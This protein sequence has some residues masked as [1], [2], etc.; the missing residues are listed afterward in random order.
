MNQKK[1]NIKVRVALFENGMRQ[2]ELAEMID[3]SESTMS[4]I[5]RG[6]LSESVQGELVKAINGD[7]EAPANAKKMLQ[8]EMRRK[9]PTMICKPQ[10][11][12]QKKE[13]RYA[14]RIL[15]DVRYY[16]DRNKGDHWI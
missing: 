6:E 15:D 11:K 9:M 5:M 10:K 14:D 2:W 4:R 12:V 8:Q 16:T 3:V 1:N 13:D 7:A